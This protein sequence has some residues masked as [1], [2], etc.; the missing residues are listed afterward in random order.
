LTELEMCGYAR[1]VLDRLQRGGALGALWWCYADYAREIA[2]LP[3]FDQAAHELSFG[4]VRS[5]GSLKPVAQ[6][7][8]EFARERR[9]VS[10]PSWPPLDEGAH[11]AG[12]P[13]S[14]ADEYARYL[15]GRVTP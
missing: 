14:T 15:N 6:T 3:P 1:E 9:E 11:Y 10:V 4:I 12:L 13:N 5:D 7:L 2:H 8:A